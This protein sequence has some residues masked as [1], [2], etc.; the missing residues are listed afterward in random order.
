VRG[1]RAP[2]STVATRCPPGTLHPP[3]TTSRAASTRKPGR[4][5]VRAT[6]VRYDRTVQVNHGYSR[7]HTPAGQHRHDDVRSNSQADV[8]TVPPGDRHTSDACWVT[9]CVTT[10]PDVRTA[11]R[12]STDAARALTLTFLPVLPPRRLLGDEEVAGSNPVTP[13]DKRP[14]QS[15]RSGSATGPFDRLPV[16]RGEDLEISSLGGSHAVRAPH[17]RPIRSSPMAGWSG[18][19]A[20]CCP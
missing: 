7:P 15:A 20:R 9:N 18:Q 4:I 1:S 12:T 3:T 11:P 17:G 2:H 6:S 5:R 10:Q 16:S 19:R 13:T 14:G 8:A